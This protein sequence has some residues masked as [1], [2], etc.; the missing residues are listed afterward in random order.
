MVDYRKFLGKRA[1][2]VLPYLGGPT[3]RAADRR[4]RV[5]HEVPEGWW[6]FSVDGRFATAEEPAE[7]PDLSRRPQVRGHL[8]DSWLF[9]GSKDIERVHLLPAE[10]IAPL[11]NVAA[12]RWSGDALLFASLEFDTE[13]EELARRALEELAPIA[14]VKGASPGLRAAHGF[15]L[16]RKIAARQ[17]MQVS[18]L[19]T[20]HEL[21]RIADAGSEAAV[22]VLHAI[23]A[24]RRAELERHQAER[25]ARLVHRGAVRQ[26]SRAAATRQNATERADAALEAAGAQL[27]STRRLHDGELEVAFRF[28]GER[29]VAVIDEISFQ[30]Y[31]AGI[32]LS[33]ADREVN[34]E[35][36]P[37]VIREA[38]DS[39]LLVVTRR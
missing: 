9:R 36:L 32:C 38:I 14:N 27:L 6:R 8:L 1:E 31:D 20:R 18:P 39:G 37:S 2:E 16:L 13:P 29:F 28:Q 22:E 23:E 11:S 24:R 17:G 33:G 4:L 21:A 10:E 12:V 7:P 5:R 25:G 19:E 30:V 35:S 26:P 15:G 34:L 3:V